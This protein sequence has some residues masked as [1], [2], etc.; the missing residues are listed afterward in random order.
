MVAEVGRVLMVVPLVEVVPSVE[1]V[2][3]EVVPM[4]V[5]R[6]RVSLH[7]SLHLSLAESAL[8]SHTESLLY[9]D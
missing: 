6:L 4:A 7:L 9:L 3:I 2:A 1:V 5:C 8:H